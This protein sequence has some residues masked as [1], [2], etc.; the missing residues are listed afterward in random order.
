MRRGIIEPMRRRG[1][2]RRVLGHTLSAVAV[3][4]AA[5]APLRAEW[6]PC[7]LPFGDCLDQPVSTVSAPP[8]GAVW[9]LTTYAYPWQDDG[10]RRWNSAL[11]RSR[12]GGLLWD[13][14]FDGDYADAN[15]ALHLPFKDVT[16]YAMAFRDA[17][18][19]WLAGVRRPAP[20]AVDA[21]PGD[22][23]FLGTSDGG[24]SWSSVSLPNDDPEPVAPGS[25]VASVKADGGVLVGA[26]QHLFES[27]D[28]VAWRERR[29]P[30][31]RFH[32]IQA[33]AWPAP[34]FA[35]DDGA[36]TGYAG[37]I[38]GEGPVIEL[39]A[40]GSCLA[41]RFR[42]ARTG[43][44]SS[45]DGA[46]GRIHLTEDGGT[47]W[48]VVLTVPGAIVRSLQWTC[49][50]AWALGGRVDGPGG[51]IYRSADSGATWSSFAVT[52]GAVWSSSF[53]DASHGYAGVEGG[54]LRFVPLEGDADGD[55]AVTASDVRLLLRRAAGLEDG[56]GVLPDAVRAL[57]LSLG[58]SAH[59]R[60]FCDPD[61]VVVVYNNRSPDSDGDGVGDSLQVARY[62]A[63][64]RG[65]PPGN[66][67]GVSA[68][69]TEGFEARAFDAGEGRANWTDA[70][71]A[72][73]EP[74]K[75]HIE[76]LGRSSVNVIVLCRGL[77]YR[78]VSAMPDGTPDTQSLDAAIGDI[79]RTDAVN[80]SSWQPYT[81]PCD[82]LSARY[83]MPRFEGTGRP[84]GQPAADAGGR[85]TRDPVYIVSRLDGPSLESVLAMV[86][87]AVFAEEHHG[88]AGYTGAA[89]VDTRASRFGRPPYALDD[90]RLWLPAFGTYGDMDRSIARSIISF[91]DR[92][93]PWRDEVTSS[94]IGGPPADE[95][96]NGPV[97]RDGTPATSAPRAM[98][99][100]G[101]YN[102]STYYDVWDW[103]PGSV[104]I[105]YSS[106]SAFAVRGHPTVSYWAPGA[107]GRGLTALVGVIAEPYGYHPAPDVLTAYLA[108]GYSFGEAATLS[109]G[110][111][112]TAKP[113]IVGDPLYRPFSGSG[114]PVPVPALRTST[115]PGADGWVVRVDSDVPARLALRYTTD[116]SDPSGSGIAIEGPPFYA[117]RASFGVPVPSA[118]YVIEAVDPVG[119]T[120][121]TES[122][123]LPG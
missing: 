13:L 25:C 6:V 89:Y 122:A 48:R 55:G 76:A 123:A 32:D 57:R 41:V 100:A 40:P 94:S 79:W 120:S 103:L 75:R 59:F 85:T 50:G 22:F 110:R 87:N 114:V 64:R 33:D 23:V 17:A 116:G 69:L 16:L 12:N 118:R 43:L 36:G 84:L 117:H 53:G 27:D 63:E 37:C 38:G 65:V 99:Y 47:T 42:D 88:P 56:E 70:Y 5:T 74:L 104:G 60:P 102:P 4:V 106:A 66:L 108:S 24:R 95:A 113:L 115:R 61:G 30:W 21:P 8:G 77:P 49:S 107:L 58:E 71:G 51:T 82:T 112:R 62:Y 18:R 15:E 2:V 119:R 45:W 35:G 73:V 78:F 81:A 9:A 96:V 31:P 90:L 83:G 109:T 72:V 7:D 80:W 14:A 28:G 105:D 111:P 11:F 68:P 54:V 20:F 97:W 39:T 10:H 26:G 1:S 92:Q 91:A 101:W 34:R 46:S 19:G 67:L 29:G 93:Y 86:D 3:L 98:F 52:P 44:V 121:R